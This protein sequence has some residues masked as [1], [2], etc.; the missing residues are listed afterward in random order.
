MR[1]FTSINSIF[2]QGPDLEATEEEIADFIESML[3]ELSLLA[4]ARVTSEEV[5]ERISEKIVL[6]DS[7]FTRKRPRM[8]C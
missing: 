8:L 7:Y 4:A 5:Q 3:N 6:F 1:R 2:C